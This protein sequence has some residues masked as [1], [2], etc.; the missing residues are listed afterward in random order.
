MLLVQ[1][2]GSYVGAGGGVSQNYVYF[3]GG[4]TLRITVFGDL[5]WVPP[6]LGNCH[7]AMV[8]R[9]QTYVEDI[10]ISIYVSEP[11]FGRHHHL[12][13]LTLSWTLLALQDSEQRWA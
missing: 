10:S 6:V 8:G 1:P 7:M 5:Y 2:G 12:L 9:L 4:P 11:T 13:G 3:L